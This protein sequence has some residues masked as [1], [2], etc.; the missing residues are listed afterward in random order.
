[1]NNIIKRY[2]NGSFWGIPK[3]VF[4]IINVIYIRSIEV[5]SSWFWGFNLG[6]C[7]SNLRIQKGATLRYPKNIKVGDNVS[8]G[9][10]CHLVSDF[11][12]SKLKIGDNSQINRNCE[13]DFSG[14]LI[15]GK[16]VVISDQVSIMTHDH[17]YDPHSVPLKNELLIDDNAWIGSYVVILPKVKIIGKNSIIASG[18][19]V[20]KTIPE[21]TVF[22]GNPVRLLK[23]RH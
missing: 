20:T 18:S 22:A 2:W 7:G 8:I 1:M 3:F 15:I 19:V 10:N 17:G 16:N 23:L 13:I 6:E 12:D 9:R 21:G 11:N 14:N 4:I 5:L